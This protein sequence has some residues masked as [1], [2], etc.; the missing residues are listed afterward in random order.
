LNSFVQFLAEQEW[1]EGYPS[2]IINPERRKPFLDYLKRV[3]KMPIMTSADSLISGGYTAYSKPTLALSILRESILGRE[4]FDFAFKQ[5][6]R[7]WMFKRPTPYDLFRTIEDASGRDLDWF[8]NG[9]FYSTDHVDIAVNNLTRYTLETRDPEIDK[10]RKREKRDELSTPLVQQRN[11]SIKKLVERKPELKDFYNQFDELAVVPGDRTAYEKLLKSL[12]PE[13][14][15]LL[16]IKGHFYAVEFENVGGVVMPLILEVAHTDG[17]SRTLRL[18][19]EIWR[20]GDREI[21][22]LIISRKPIASIEFDPGD[23]LADLD[24]HN[25][26][27][28]RLPMEKTFRLQKS[29]K[30]KNPMQKAIE[31]NKKAEDE[32]KKAEGEKKR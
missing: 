27:F 23:E 32:K 24:R 4:N 2:R 3:R 29:K 21:S 10:A 14:K 31:A 1:E 16:K 12:K 7:R 19:A 11:R 28:P 6:A 8:W 9:W 18:P 30:E 26:R 5:Y 17:T 25:N 15:Q 13:E 22:K 20:K